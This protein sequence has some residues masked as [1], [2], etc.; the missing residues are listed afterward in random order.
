MKIPPR[1]A[2]DI[3]CSC[4]CC[5]FD[6]LTTKMWCSAEIMRNVL[7]FLQILESEPE[8]NLFISPVYYQIECHGLG[9]EIKSCHNLQ[10][11][12]SS[13]PTTAWPPYFTKWSQLSKM[14][15]FCRFWFDCM[16]YSLTIHQ[17]LSPIQFKTWVGFYTSSFNWGEWESECI[18]CSNQKCTMLF[19]NTH[20][21]PQHQ[22][23]KLFHIESGQWG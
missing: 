20:W 11:E 4:Y 9:C 2:T 6:N 7:M 14:V 21:K 18:V 5:V 22:Q 12:N 16:K 15:R 23:L 1:S 17:S 10:I 19:I 8:Q 3:R 13:R